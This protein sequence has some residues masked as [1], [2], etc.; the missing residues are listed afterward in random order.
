MVKTQFSTKVKRVRSDN[1]TEFT[2]SVF[3]KILQ[4]EGIMHETSCVGTPQQNGRVERKH[5]HILNVA[6]A[7]RFHAS[8]PVSFWGECV[9]AATYIINRTPTMA[10]NG[11]TPYELL[12]GKPP[13]YN[14]MKIVGCLSY[15]RNSSKQK[16]KIDARAERCMFVGYPQGQKGWR[17]YNMKTREFLVSRDVIFYENVFPYAE[18]QGSTREGGSMPT[19]HDMSHH[20][21]DENPLDYE[22]G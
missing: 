16:D 15:V 2:N 9:L 6:R 17:V 7:L 10:N 8:L 14:Q 18:K 3:Q 19:F 4:Q 13:S 20:T 1:G 5:R 11:V 21:E 12:F 22:Q